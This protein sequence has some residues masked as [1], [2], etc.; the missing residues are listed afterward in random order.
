MQTYETN[1]DAYRPGM[2]THTGPKNLLSRNFEGAVG[3]VLEFGMPVVQSTNSDRAVRAPAAGDT[4]IFGISVLERSTTDG[5]F[6]VGDTARIATIG[7]VAVKVAA[8][9]NA[10]DPVHVIVADST[11][12][13]TGGVVVADARF[14][15]S[16]S[17]GE[18]AIVRMK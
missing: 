18:L 7:P 1:M 15:T 12:S 11:F 9:V 3:D 13:N 5:H 17:A 14:D 6:A 4:E 8:D 2:Q 16:A 10:G